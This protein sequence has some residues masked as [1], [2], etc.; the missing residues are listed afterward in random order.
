MEISQLVAGYS[1]GDAISNEARELRKLFRSW[2][3]N[4]EIYVNIQFLSPELRGACRDYRQY[5]KHDSPDN[6]I[7]FHFSVGSKLTDF[8]RGLRARKVVIY[9]NI[10]PAKYYQGINPRAAEALAKGREELK[11]FSDVPGLALGDS[12]YNVRELVELGYRKTGVLPLL[13]DLQVFDRTPPDPEIMEKFGGN[14][15]GVLF[16]GRIAPNKK[17]EDIIKAFYIYQKTCRANSRLFLVGGYDQLDPYY[18]Y[19]CGLIRELD[20]RNVWFAGHASLPELVAYWRLADVFLSMSEHEGFGI[21]LI[22]SM[23]FGIPVIAYAAGAVEETMG[24]TGILIRKKN[25]NEI[26]EIIDMVTKDEQFR[27][28]IVEKQLRRTKELHP[29]IIAEKLRSHL[30]PWLK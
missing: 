26:A 10:T 7:I 22:E 27:N 29:D 15:I 3:Y 9:H 18:T 14:Y 23:H 12:D 6:I 11:S 16:V 17:F 5:L 2:G 30:E 1:S 21:P 25:Y 8:V 20:V 13:L 28:R 19:L 4:S 24:G